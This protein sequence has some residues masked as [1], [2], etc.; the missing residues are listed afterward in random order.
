MH[1]IEKSKSGEMLIQPLGTKV[2]FVP[3]MSKETQLHKY[4]RSRRLR[5][6]QTGNQQH[7]VM[8]MLMNLD[9]KFDWKNIKWDSAE[10][11]KL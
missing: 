1:V 8:P 5:V 7:I 6:V 9:P 11:I 4:E 2:R 3:L 10:S